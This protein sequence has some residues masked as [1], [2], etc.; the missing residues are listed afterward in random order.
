MKPSQKTQV[1]EYLRTHEYI[2]PLD[3]LRDIGSF[4]LGARIYDLKKDGYKIVNDGTN[5]HGK[6]RLLSEAHTSDLS[7]VKGSPTQS[8]PKQEELDENMV[9]VW[10]NAKGELRRYIPYVAPTP[11]CGQC[12]I[13]FRLSENGLQ[14]TCKHIINGRCNIN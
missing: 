8:T 12:C 1:L 7:E 2:T 11:S 5:E 9:G 4:R 10:R 14:N 6:Y 13:Y 3:A